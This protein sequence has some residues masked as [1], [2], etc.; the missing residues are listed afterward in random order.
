MQYS[1]NTGHLTDVNIL[2]YLLLYIQTCLKN[3]LV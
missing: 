2:A 1:K 3:K